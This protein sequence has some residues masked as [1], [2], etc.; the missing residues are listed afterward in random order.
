MHKT[1]IKVSAIVSTYNSSAFIEGCL[2]NLIAQTMRD[3][4]EIIVIDS[5]SEECEGEIVASISAEFERVR[6]IRT[7]KRETLYAAWNR[8]IRLASGKYITNANTDD[9]SR[10]DAYEILSRTLDVNADVALAYSDLYITDRPNEQYDRIKP[11]WRNAEVPEYSQLA[12]LRTCLCGPRPMYRK[13]V[14]E[15]IGWYNEDYVSAGDYEFWLRLSE[16]FR[17]K[18]VAE[19]LSLFYINY[20]GISMSSGKGA[21]EVNEILR[22]FLAGEFKK[23]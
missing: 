8:A 18:R 7:A 23:P 13:S 12:L 11:H 5:G 17:M 19:P 2:R 10:K 20:G 21:E 16:R 14:H 9:R 1:R 4:I 15:T 6:Y 3:H 22:K